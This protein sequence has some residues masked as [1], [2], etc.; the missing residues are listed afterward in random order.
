MGIFAWAG[1]DWCSPCEHTEAARDNFVNDSAQRFQ[2]H[3]LER[4]SSVLAAVD[5]TPGDASLHT[6]GRSSNGGRQLQESLS[7]RPSS[8]GGGPR[9]ATEEERGIADITLDME[10]TKRSQQGHMDSGS[11]RGDWPPCTWKRS[12]SVQT[13]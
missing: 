7:R 12:H 10:L 6:N 11:V 8:Q 2:E 1:V 9:L 13:S 5:E 3:P 4:A